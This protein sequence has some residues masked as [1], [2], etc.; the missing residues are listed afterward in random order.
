MIKEGEY[1]S[2]EPTKEELKIA[3]LQELSENINAYNTQ[4]KNVIKCIGEYI[5]VSDE[6]IKEKDD[7]IKEL[8]VN[9]K[10]VVSK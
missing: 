9:K 8:Q 7:L 2:R 4:L 6:V 5:K 1:M 10:G 3:K